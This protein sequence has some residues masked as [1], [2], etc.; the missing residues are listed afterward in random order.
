ML[1]R[2]VVVYFLLVFTII[3]VDTVIGGWFGPKCTEGDKRDVLSNCV[4]NLEK[5]NPAT[6]APVG[7]L[8]CKVVREIKGTKDGMMKCIVKLLTADEKEQYDE[9]RI[10]NLKSQCSLRPSSASFD[11]VKITSC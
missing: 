8:C 1:S 5:S 9:T 11:E 10:L 2:K 7:G 6:P 3:G 4:L